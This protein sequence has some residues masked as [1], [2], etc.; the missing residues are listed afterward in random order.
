M[1]FQHTWKGCFLWVGFLRLPNGVLTQDHGRS[2]LAGSPFP[3][4]THRPPQRPPPVP[5]HL[6]LPTTLSAHPLALKSPICKEGDLRQRI[7][8]VFSA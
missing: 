5:L 4:E 1:G 6:L 8:V 7:P 3:L 2:N